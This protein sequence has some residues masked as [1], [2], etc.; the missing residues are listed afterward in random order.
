VVLFLPTGTSLCINQIFHKHVA[1]AVMFMNQSYD[2]K[3][4]NPV[5]PTRPFFH[6]ITLTGTF[7]IAVLYVFINQILDQTVIINN[8]TVVIILTSLLDVSGP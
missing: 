1:H 4:Q 8:Q 2:L 6:K 5:G 3:E 7:Y